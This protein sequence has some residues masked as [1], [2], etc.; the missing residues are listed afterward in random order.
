M[1]TSKHLEVRCCCQ[2]HKLLGYLP[3]NDYILKR[4]YAVWPIRSCSYLSAVKDAITEDTKF[5]VITL[6]IETIR[7]QGRS[8]QAYKAEG[9]TVEEL[10]RI[11]GFVTTL[12]T[13]RL[14][15]EYP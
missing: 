10:S 15:L 3:V 14:H 4:G 12:L 8:Y 6:P 2:P 5:E 9:K 7:Y 11:S 13:D 1:F